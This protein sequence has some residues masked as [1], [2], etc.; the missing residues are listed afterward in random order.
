MPAFRSTVKHNHLLL[1]APD[2]YGV[3][4]ADRQIYEYDR[5]PLFVTRPEDEETW[6]RYVENEADVS[7]DKAYY[8]SWVANGAGYVAWR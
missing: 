3:S 7:Q 4:A 8:Q 1:Q 5:R 2:D 6:E